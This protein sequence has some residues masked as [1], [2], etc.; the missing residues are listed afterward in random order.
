MNTKHGRSTSEDRIHR[1]LLGDWTQINEH[2][3]AQDF[4]PLPYKPA[5]QNIRTLVLEQ[6]PLQS[7][8]ISQ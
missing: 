4:Y 6:A 7:P 1:Y 3:T 2:E 5:H 8:K